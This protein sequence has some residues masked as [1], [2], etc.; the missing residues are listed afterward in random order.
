[1]Q[2]DVKLEAALLERVSAAA[3]HVV[4]LKHKHA[5][6]ALGEQRRRCQAGGTGADDN[7]VELLGHLAGGEPLL[8]ACRP[9][10]RRRAWRCGAV[11]LR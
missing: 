5:L 8:E 6:P 4:L 7:R 11:C 1:M 9:G 2:P 10:E 3:G